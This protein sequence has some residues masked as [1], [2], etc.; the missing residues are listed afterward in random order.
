[1]CDSVCYLPDRCKY[2]GCQG[3]YIRGEIEGITV[4]LGFMGG[5]R[6]ERD[7][8]KARVLQRFTGCIKRECDCIEKMFDQVY[9]VIRDVI[10]LIK[11]G[12]R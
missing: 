4:F 2:F 11:D 6:V 8:G 10:N 7:L 9:N 5:S 3:K 1:M 12:S